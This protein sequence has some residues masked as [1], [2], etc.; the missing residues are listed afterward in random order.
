MRML[1]NIMTPD[2]KATRWR[3]DDNKFVTRAAKELL[4]GEH[5]LR[6][7]VL[8]KP[9]RTA[10]LTASAAPVPEAMITTVTFMLLRLNSPAPQLAAMAFADQASHDVYKAWFEAWEAEARSYGRFARMRTFPH[11]EK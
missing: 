2:G 11:R 6:S 8:S 5:R 1:P 3:T 10:S 9:Q 4:S 7:M